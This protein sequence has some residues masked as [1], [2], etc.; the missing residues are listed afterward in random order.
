MQHM[1]PADAVQAFKD[2][3]AETALGVHWGTFQMT[4]EAVD[5]P[6]RDLAEALS[7]QS[8]DPARFHA[9]RPGEV[10]EP[11]TA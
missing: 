4:N 8:M 10:W 6:E 5:Q 7:A 3:G 11:G 2:L 1:N 9:M